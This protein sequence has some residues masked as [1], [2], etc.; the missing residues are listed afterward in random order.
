MGPEPEVYGQLRP[1]QVGV[2]MEALLSNPATGISIALVLGT[3]VFLWY[4]I[5]G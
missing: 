3:V 5:T 4:W 2:L 1:D